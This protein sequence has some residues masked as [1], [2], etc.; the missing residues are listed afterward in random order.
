[1]LNPCLLS[2]ILTDTCST[3]A[4]AK[5]SHVAEKF[6]TFYSEIEQE[7]QVS[8]AFTADIFEL[9]FLEACVI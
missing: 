9:D 6:S 5:L 1:M 8:A 3:G 2:S 7:R 4:A